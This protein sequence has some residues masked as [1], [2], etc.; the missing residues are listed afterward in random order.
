MAAD[1]PLFERVV[2]DA[3]SQRRK[4]LRNGLKRVMQEFGVSDLPVDLGLRPENLSLAD[5]VNLCNALI[6]QKAADDQ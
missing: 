5:Y 1:I 6:R 3:F 4:T 2:R